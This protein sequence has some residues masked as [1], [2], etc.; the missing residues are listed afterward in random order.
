[1]LFMFELFMLELSLDVC[2]L[3]ELLELLALKLFLFLLLKTE[4]QPE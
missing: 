4:D 2:M 3:L 1:M